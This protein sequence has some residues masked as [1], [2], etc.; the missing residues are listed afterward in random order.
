MLELL[1]LALSEIRLQTRRR[2]TKASS[3][4]R[5]SLAPSW[6]VCAFDRAFVLAGIEN[7]LATLFAIFFSHGALDLLAFFG[8]RHF[9]F[10]SVFITL[11]IE[12]S[13]N[14]QPCAAQILTQGIPAA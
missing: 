13:T 6:L 1:A 14:L 10:L 4:L 11:A 3:F 5:L 2:E 9:Y 12:P 7:A 8:Q